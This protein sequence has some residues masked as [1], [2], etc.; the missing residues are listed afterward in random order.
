MYS[1]T[2]LNCLIMRKVYK[3][4]LKREI[5]DS[6]KRLFK[7]KRNHERH[8]ASDKIIRNNKHYAMP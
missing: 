4:E 6:T 1:T 3:F 8:C 7:S 5:T 2:I